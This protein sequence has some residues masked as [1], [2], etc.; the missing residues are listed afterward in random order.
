MND[1]CKLIY[2]NI[3][4][5]ITIFKLACFTLTMYVL[6]IKYNLIIFLIIID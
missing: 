1:I 6:F 3:Y 4:L 5:R 2:I